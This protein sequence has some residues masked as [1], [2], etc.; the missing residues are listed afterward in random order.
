MRGQPLQAAFCTLCLAGIAAVC[1]SATFQQMPQPLELSAHQP[2]TPEAM[3][4]HVPSLPGY[5][6]LEFGLYSGHITVDE[7]AGRALYYIFAESAYTVN[8]PLV[9]WMNG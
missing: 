1:V 2:V 4:D 9:I 3:A 7:K 6:K 5:G 8:A